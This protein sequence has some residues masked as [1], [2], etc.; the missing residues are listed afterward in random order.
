M[1]LSS[2][3]IRRPDAQARVHP[4]D[5]C[6]M[7]IFG[8]SGD[9][10]KRL[11]MPALYNLVRTKVLP[12]NFALIGVARTVETAESWRG[13]LYDMLKS[14]VGDADHID[15]AAWKSLAERM[16]YVPGDLTKP[17]LYEK[18]R[19]ALDA[20]EKI[21]RHSGQRHFLSG[22]LPIGCSAPWCRPARQSAARRSGGTSGGQGRFW[23]RVVIE[24]PFG[25]SLDSAR[26]LNAGILRTLH[27]DQI[28]RIDHFL[29]KDTV[30]G[31]MAFRFANG[32]FE[33][34]WNRDRIDHVQITV[35]ETVG[36]EQ[37]GQFYEATGALRDMV[38]N[39]VFALL[40]MVAMEPPVGFDEA[41]IRTKKA[42]LFAAIPAVKP[43]QAVRGQYGAGTV[44]GK[45]VKGYRQEPDVA[46]NSNVETY[47]AMQFEIDNWRWAGVPFY[48]RTG[49]HMSQRNT[50]I[51]IRFKQAPYAAFQDTPVDTLRPNWLVLSIAPDE[52]ISLQ[53]EVKRRGPVVDLAAVKMDFRYDDWFAKEPNVGYETLLYDVM[54]GDPTLF[55]RA[56]M[57][58]QGWRIVQP[59]LD[60]WAANKADFPNYESGSDGPTAAD[61]LLARDGGRAWRP[62]ARRRDGKAMSGQRGIRLVLADVDGTLVTNDKILTEAAKAAARELHHAGI[63][64]AITS[65]R[66]P[67]GMSM[68]IEPLALH[69]AIAGFNGG[70]LVNPDLSVIESHTLDPATARQALQ[71]ILDQGLDAWVYTGKEW[72]IR[73]QGAPHVA[74]E[75]WTVKFD[76][77]VVSSFTDADLAQAVKIVGVSDDLALVAACEKAGDKNALGD[78]ASA[79]R[80]QP[81]YLDVTHPQANKGAV[82]ATLSRLLNIPTAQIATIGDMPNDALMFRKSGFSIAMGNASD[83]VKAQ[84]R[85]VTDSNENEGFAK[86]MR[87]FILP[88]AA[89]Q[90]S[91]P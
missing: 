41:S 88:L 83:A 68:L 91:S 26:E 24:K 12:E 65:G 89:A 56:D 29:G 28:F 52:G 58:E 84:A 36:V 90:E 53:F 44:L 43:A 71:L 61:E 51:A 40:S 14:F 33:P 60:A 78:R 19:G 39:H 35:A 81:Y 3:S 72:L 66:P 50:E 55:M 17:E 48:I 76:A 59:V 75:A 45:P 20:A 79:A 31:I 82:V 15:D 4:A 9:L 70:V 11:V 30:Q 2:W 49:K 23:R 8:A 5:P 37:R 16:S 63:T 85:A 21:H 27:E 38:P 25:H 67:R 42:E 47:V 86:A 13:L 34:I 80:S 46:P 54:I 87:K 73:D 6:V 57:V 18:L 32:L 64:L 74:R 7:V 22:R 69:G 1:A 77:R 10:T 62:V